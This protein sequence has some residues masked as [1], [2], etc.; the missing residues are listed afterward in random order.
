MNAQTRGAMAK[1]RGY[2]QAWLSGARNPSTF[3]WIVAFFAVAVQYGA[4]V[5]DNGTDL[6]I[7]DPV[8]PRNTV[9][10]AVSLASIV[11]ASSF[12]YR[13]IVLLLARN[14][15]ILA[16]I[17]LV[18][19]SMA[20]SIHPDLT[21]RRSIGCILSI[22]VAAYLSVRFGEMDRM[23]V[24][25]FTFALSAIGSLLFVAAYPNY[26]I[27][28]GD[29]RG[30]FEN[31]N[32]LGS[33]MAAAIF[34]EL[35]LL[36][37]GNWRPIWRLGLLSIYL[38]LLILSHSLTSLICAALY[39]A[40]TAVYV[41]GKGDKLASLIVAITLG[42]PLLLLQLGLWYNADVLLSVFGKNATLTGRTDLWL[43]TLDLIKQKPLLGWGYMATW[44]PTDPQTTTIWQKF[45]WRVPNAHSAYLDVTFQLGLVGLGLLLTIIIRA[46][47]RARACC[48]REVLPLGWFSLMLIL[49][50]LLFSISETGLGQNQQ[51]YW[52][53]L[54]VFNFSCGL[55][56][57]CLRGRGQ[58]A[59]KYRRRKKVWQKRLL[60]NG[61][62][63]ISFDGLRILGTRR[64]SVGSAGAMA[65]VSAKA[66]GLETKLNSPA[67]PTNSMRVACIPLQI[68]CASIACTSA[69]SLHFQNVANVSRYIRSRSC[70]APT[71]PAR[72]SGS[73]PYCTA[74]THCFSEQLAHRMILRPAVNTITSSSLQAPSWDCR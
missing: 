15:A 69:L 60:R 68:G 46:W 56:L 28:S 74:S 11:I 16:Y 45:G 26:G 66:L 51:I 1:S 62:S 21:F 4:R 70:A 18:A 9:C 29:W 37:L 65:L 22:L 27:D 41:I 72:P 52:L 59:R 64:K 32:F 3:A 53:L 12:F 43:A 38:T 58:F 2:Q 20:W 57:A 34:V 25:S 17:S 67:K 24:F 36:V 39:L 19:I 31:K 8:D 13:D 7:N 35:Y 49:G 50:A 5:G 55:S 30:L 6:S 47:Q 23:K 44:V 63:T 40:G 73:M 71:R 33:I 42:L 14:K 48:R 10:V 61:K 54:N